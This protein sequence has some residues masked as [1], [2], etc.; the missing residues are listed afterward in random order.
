MRPAATVVL[1][2][3]LVAAA[4]ARPPAKPRVYDLIAGGEHEYT[5]VAGDSLWSIT[6]RFTMNRALLESWNGFADPDV[7]RPGMPVDVW[8]GAGGK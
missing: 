3:A 5:V 6:G 4:H 7:L 8:L 2:A 1:F